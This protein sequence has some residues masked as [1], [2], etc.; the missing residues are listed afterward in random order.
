MEYIYRSQ[1]VQICS[2][3]NL[4]GSQYSHLRSSPH[5]ASSTWLKRQRVKCK[6]GKLPKSHQQLLEK[7]GV[8]LEPGKS[9]EERWQGKVLALETFIQREG[10]AKILWTWRNVE[11]MIEWEFRCVRVLWRL[12]TSFFFLQSLWKNCAKWRTCKVIP[13]EFIEVWRAHRIPRHCA[14]WSG[15]SDIPGRCV[16]GDELLGSW[17]DAQRSRWKLGKLAPER[18]SVMEKPS[19][20]CGDGDKKPN[21]SAKSL[22]ICDFDQWGYSFF[23]LG[24][25]NQGFG[26]WFSL[27]HVW[28]VT[29][30]S[31]IPDGNVSWRKSWNWSLDNQFE[32]H[33]SVFDS[34]KTLTF[35]NGYC[36]A[37]MD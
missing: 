2:F 1:I 20:T 32:M 18:A 23:G 22:K 3:L 14:P 9:L 10:G 12:Y 29:S 28:V 8:N 16:E 35:S 13:A 11:P 30:F 25:R 17:L 24:P 19:A 6:Q 21:L 15:H 34:C 7:L 26:G 27:I 36:I 31:Q 33:K 4:F 37:K 5:E